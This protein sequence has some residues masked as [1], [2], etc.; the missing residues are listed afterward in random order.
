MLTPF[1]LRKRITSEEA[2]R[3]AGAVAAGEH[4]GELRRLRRAVRRVVVRSAAGL[5]KDL[6]GVRLVRCNGALGIACPARCVWGHQEGIRLSDRTGRYFFIGNHDSVDL[7]LPAW[8]FCDWM[9][10]RHGVTII[11]RFSRGEFSARSSELSRALVA[12]SRRWTQVLNS[13]PVG[14]TVADALKLYPAEIVE[15]SLDYGLG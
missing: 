14:C 8:S 10:T 13:L 5:Y 1:L 2:R 12:R 15:A 4:A 7:R 9:L 6:P 11:D 3:V